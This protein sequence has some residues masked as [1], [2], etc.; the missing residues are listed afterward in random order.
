VL[1][2]GFHEQEHRWSS[3]RASNEFRESIGLHRF[4]M[5]IL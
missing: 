4:M 5:L 2:D 1:G 3:R